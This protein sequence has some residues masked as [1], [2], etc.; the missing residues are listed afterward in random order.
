MKRIITALA[1][2]TAF[3]VTPAIADQMDPSSDQTKLEAKD[4]I[5]VADKD[6]TKKAMDSE[7]TAMKAAQVFLAIDNENDGLVEESEWAEWQ[8]RSAQNTRQFSEY[9]ADSDGDIELSEYLET[10]DNS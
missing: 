7:V 10:Y 5:D 2:T 1:A 3:A 8:N 6:W 9:D 4:D